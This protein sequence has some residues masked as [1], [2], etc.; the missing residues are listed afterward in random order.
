MRIAALDLGS[1]TSLLLIADVEDG[2]LRQVLHDETTITRL[3]Q[4]VHADRRFHPDALE[5]MRQCLTKYQNTIREFK[6]DRVVAVATS[7]ARDVANGQDLI[8]IGRER[9]IPIHIISGAQEAQLTFRGA[10][11]DRPSTEGLAVIDVG[12]GSTEVI[13]NSLGTV[14]GTSVDVGSVRLTE[15]FVKSDPIRPQEQTQVRDYAAAAFARAPIP[16]GPFREVVAVAGTPTTLAA[17]DQAID[18]KEELIHNYKLSLQKI[19]TWIERLAKMSLNE[20]EKLKGMQPKRADV[21]VPGSVILGAAIRALQ[22]T[23]VT[24]STRGVRYGVALA[25]QDF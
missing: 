20:R 19:D 4:G 23:E 13:T 18:F 17:L 12:G 11:C 8:Q 24:V 15:L 16:Q 25:W 22:Q 21:I 1:N 3:G 6:C 9:Q 5:R 14:Q 2:Q 10:V 7:A